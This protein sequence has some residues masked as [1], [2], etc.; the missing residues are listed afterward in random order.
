M[1]VE[2]KFG[3][4]NF[5]IETGKMAK[6]A[7]GSVCVQYGGTVVLVTAVAS[8]KLREGIGFFPLTVEY[9]EKTY[10][11][12][13]IP[14]GYFK[15]EGRPTE[16]EIL[17]ARLIDRPIRPLFPKGFM[18]DVQIFAIV[19]S[20]D[21]ENDSDIL[22]LIGASVSLSISDIPFGGPIGAVKV[23]LVD[24]KFVVNPTFEE[25]D[26]STLNLMA[27]GLKERIVMLEAGAN[28]V[29]DEKMLEA[30]K[31]AQ[32]YI[33]E[34]IELQEEL[35]KK[36]G[37]KKFEPEL[38]LVADELYEKVKKIAQPK[39]KDI[40][41]QAVKAERK[42]ALD[43]LC[44]ELIEKLKGEDEALTDGDIKN[45][46]EKVEK[47]EVR[48][49]ILDKKIRLDGRKSEDIRTITCEVG[50]LPRTHGSGLFT[51]GETQS[52]STTT[53][54][55][56]RDEQRLDSLEGEKFKSF[57]LHYNF[58]PFSVGEARPA[59]GPGRREIGHGAL[60]EKALKSI[61]PSNEDFPYTIRIVSDILESNG[62]SSMATVCAG[63]LSLMD[64][65]VPIKK[66]VSGIA[67]GLV[68]EGKKAIILTDIAGEEDHFGDMDFKVA[69]TDEGITAL[70]MDLKTDGIDIDLIK[71]IMKQAKPAKELLLKSIVAAIESPRQSLSEYAPKIV[72]IAIDKGK[73]RDVIGPGGKIIKRI[74]QETGAEINID[75]EAGTVSISSSS[76]E[77]I[78][79]A[80]EI[81]KGITGD[82]EVGKVFDG[83]ITR[84]MNFGAFCEILPG[85]EGLIHVSEIASG[86]VKNVE[87]RVKVGDKVKVKLIK[88]DDQGRLN[89]SIKQA[90]AKEK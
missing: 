65:G 11:A 23:G 17:T 78:N 44:S 16:K 90:E 40:L 87:D 88:V 59:R 49:F 57:M 70:Q 14:G 79:K 56:S 12:G 18:N 21:G 58:P 35:I 19:L 24:D 48:K 31:F 69:G 29:T 37:K 10:A 1:K 86:F 75:D 28:E 25:R 66:P 4:E 43:V 41:S 68:K 5:I 46:L 6:Q 33:K 71:K 3:R 53:L 9:Q 7:S 45:A 32:K 26:A 82:V 85:K 8:K 47:E 74:I 83:T 60:A 54:G 55:T 67:M 36:C 76:D 64:A 30:I 20:S 39:L 42:E 38:K 34:T 73:I 50:V 2:R 80:M 15:R 52:L 22:G 89:L 77:A 63:T 61:L 51:R 27:V 81:V 62:S 13:K 72:S 84:L